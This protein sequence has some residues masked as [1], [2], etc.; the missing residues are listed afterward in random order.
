M[1]IKH[2]AGAKVRGYNQ[3]ELSHVSVINKDYVLDE[4]LPSIITILDGEWEQT[5]SAS[6]EHSFNLVGTK[7]HSVVNNTPEIAIDDV[8]TGVYRR[9]SS[10]QMSLAVTDTTGTTKILTPTVSTSSS[11]DSSVFVEFTLGTLARHLKDNFDSLSVPET[12]TTLLNKL[13]NNLATLSPEKNGSNIVSANFDDSGLMYYANSTLGMAVSPRHVLTASHVN[14][15][16]ARTVYFVTTAGEIISRQ[17]VSMR[18]TYGGLEDDIGL[19]Y[20]DAD[21][22]ANV[23]PLKILPADWKTKLPDRNQLIGEN[24]FVPA[25]IHMNNSAKVGVVSLSGKTPGSLGVDN[26]IHVSTNNNYS[27]WRPGGASSTIVTLPI[28]GNLVLAGSYYYQ[29]GGYAEMGMPDFSQY[30]STI[31]AAMTTMHGSAEHQLQTVD[32]SGFTTI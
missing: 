14:G 7:P 13:N 3:G 29:T 25:F 12:P 30:I 11:V 1:K 23:T 4:A 21:L 26:A 20:L 17:A 16:G 27:Q 9:V 22:P 31:N 8:T 5:L 24:G 32:L 6:T 18:T 10:G 15:G 2:G 19:S 28:N